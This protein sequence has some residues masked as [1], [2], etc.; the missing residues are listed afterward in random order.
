[1]TIE[2]LLASITSPS[3]GSTGSSV[4]DSH[5]N[6]TDSDDPEL[7][8]LLS[9][10]DAELSK[11][12]SELSKRVGAAT[13][14][15]GVGAG[16]KGLKLTGDGSAPSPMHEVMPEP[17]FVVKTH[18]TVKVDDWGVGLKVF[19]NICHSPNIPAP[20]PATKE[21]IV[22]A[23]NAEDNAAYKVP[24]SLS[25]PRPD[26]DKSGKT[27][28]V[29]DA[30]VNTD[31]LDKAAEDGDFKLF[32]IELALEWVEEKYKLQLSREFTLP[33]MASKGRLSKHIIRRAK[34]PIIA[35]VDRPNGSKSAAKSTA[36]TQL[37]PTAMK[38]LHLPRPKYDIV[39]EPPTSTPEF[40]IVEIQLPGVPTM[41]T[42][43][44]DIEQSRLL[45]HIPN[46]FA[47][48]IDLPHPIDVAEGGAQFHRGD[49][50]LTV[51]LTVK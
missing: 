13:D 40:L 45:L 5:P 3:G 4:A 7:V 32:L 28:L 36:P 41:K 46:H 38:T 49:K 17:G 48:D 31:P 11:L 1:M 26:R 19:I 16:G 42:T 20:P 9:Q 23:L 25:S 27:C 33:K 39:R 44:L 37:K 29:F 14:Q 2:S 15:D 34:R 8:K 6:R 35:E 22:K 30:C 50:V 18:N 43:T 51:T 12:M 24:L 47:L 21:E 10:N